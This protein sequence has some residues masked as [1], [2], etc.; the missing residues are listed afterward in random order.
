MAEIRNIVG[1]YNGR[2]PLARPR[3]RWDDYI[4]IKSKEVG[5]LC[6]S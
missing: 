5:C 4:K 1:K 2:R 3:W 6:M